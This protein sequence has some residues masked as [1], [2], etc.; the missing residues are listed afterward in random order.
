MEEAIMTKEAEVPCITNSESSVRTGN[1]EVHQSKENASMGCLLPGGNVQWCLQ[2]G[3]L[4][5]KTSRCSERGGGFP[6]VEQG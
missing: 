3:K 5:R 2:G 6:T 4:T 1:A